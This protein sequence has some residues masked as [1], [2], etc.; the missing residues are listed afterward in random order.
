M[1]GSRSRSASASH[2][3]VALPSGSSDTEGTRGTLQDRIGLWALWV[4]VLSST[5]YLA[6]VITWPLVELAG[7]TLIDVLRHPGPLLHLGVSLLFLA[8]WTMTRRFRLTLPALRGLEL[9]TLWGGCGAFAVMGM[10]AVDMAG[11]LGGLLALYAGLLACSNVVVAR[12]IAVPSTPSRTL[13]ASVVAMAPVVV[14]GAMATRDVA[15]T[16][17]IANWCAVAIAIATVGSRVIFGLRTEAA[18]VRRL[19]QYTLERKLGA[20]GMGV[21]YRAHHAM[22]RRPT[23]IK[24]LPP[25]RAG[26][27][28]LVRFE[29]EVQLTAQLSHP[30]TV[31]IYDYG[32]T[33]DG[34]F[35][36]AMELL[37]GITLE[38]LVRQYGPQPP[39]RVIHIVQ[40]VCG[41]LAEAHGRGL[42]HRDI[43]PPNII[44]TERGGEADVAKVVDFGLVKPFATDT[45]SATMSASIVLA[46]TPL[47]MPPEAITRPDSVDPRSD[48]YSLGAV[49]YFLLAGQPV[50]DAA[51]MGEAL[52]HHLSTPPQPLSARV[53]GVPPDMDVIVLQCLA[54]EPGARPRDAREL[55]AALGRCVGVDAWTPEQ[56]AAWW[57]AHRRSDRVETSVTSGEPALTVAIDLDAR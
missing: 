42:L 48:L 2:I 47:Y 22:L 4:G 45:A 31:A 56:A 12:A 29:R 24:L 5:F 10:N 15:L 11:S 26:E 54:K 37:D 38:D 46:G 41:A 1:T 21:V 19:G 51:T 49:A 32:R 20:G 13:W 28:N 39:G 35:Y 3:A 9:A 52:A 16:I 40:Q 23:A 43:K 17:T 34:L 53:P 44:L 25:D 27:A 14:T 33:P 8:V 6:N 30:N 36:Y 50:F 7:Y 55:A 57:H 18:R